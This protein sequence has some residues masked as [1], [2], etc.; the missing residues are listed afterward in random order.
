MAKRTSINIKGMA[1]GAPIPMGSKI[2]N[3]VYSSGIFGTDP[4]TGKVPPTAEAQAEQAF[5]NMRALLEV[6]GGTP[7][8]II[9]V[10]VYMSDRNQRGAVNAPWLKMFPDEHARPARH[11]LETNMPEGNFVQLQCVAVLG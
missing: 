4:K 2:G 9:S 5:A 6:A 3:M 1:H 11:A 10:T 8:D 7:E